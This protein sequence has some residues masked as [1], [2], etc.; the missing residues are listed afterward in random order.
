MTIT[1]IAVSRNGHISISLK[2]SYLPYMI[3]WPLTC[4]HCTYLSIPCAPNLIRVP[5]PNHTSPNFIQSLY[6][7]HFSQAWSSIIKQ[8][9]SQSLYNQQYIT[10]STKVKQKS[11]PIIRTWCQR[12]NTESIVLQPA[13]KCVIIL[14]LSDYSHLQFTASARVYSILFFKRNVKVL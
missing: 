11:P 5:L 7:F 4:S 2:K 14:Q 12:L 1:L 9:A 6:P 10:T 3:S 13:S 8:S